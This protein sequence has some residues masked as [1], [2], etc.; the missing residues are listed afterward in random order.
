M[1]VKYFSFQE[2]PNFT[3]RL[4]KLMKDDDYAEFQITLAANP[5]AGDLIPVATVCAKCAGVEKVMANAEA[6]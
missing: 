5:S 1:A 4:L 6:S 3:K 2:T